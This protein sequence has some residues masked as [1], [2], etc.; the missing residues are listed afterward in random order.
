MKKTI[1]TILLALAVAA[2]GFSGCSSANGSSS[3]SASGSAALAS[4]AGTFP[5]VKNKTTLNILVQQNGTCSD[6]DTCDQTKAVE[7]KTGITIKWTLLPSTSDASQKL[8]LILSSN[9]LPDI[10]L[11]DPGMTQSDVYTLAQQ[12]TFIDLDSYIQKYGVETQKMFKKVSYSKELITYPDGKI[13][14]LPYINDCYHCHVYQRMFIYKPWLDKLGLKVPTTT[15]ELYN[16]LTAFKEKDPNGNGKADEVALEGNTSDTGSLA[17]FLMN[18]FTYYSIDD[19]FYVND[20]G[21]VVIPYSSDEWK[22]GLEYMRKLYKDGLVAPESFT[23]NEDQLSGIVKSSTETVGSFVDRFSHSLTGWGTD[24]EDALSN[25]YVAVSP[26]KGTNG[27]QIAVWRPYSSSHGDRFMI[28][29]ACK[30]PDVA[31]RLGDYL[32]SQE[33]TEISLMGVEGKGWTK[34]SSD[35]KGIDGREALYHQ[36]DNAPTNE[37]WGVQL[38]MVATNDMRMSMA[39]TGGAGKNLEVSLYQM[40]KNYEPY[41]VASKNVIPT[42]YFTDDQETRLSDLSQIED[43]VKES[44]ARFITG[45]LS[46]DKDWGSYVSELKSMGLSEYQQIYQDAYDNVKGK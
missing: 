27:T 36:N 46:I 31:F 14:S 18:A 11:N 28:T 35:E 10:F 8:K 12:G 33:Q 7:K 20:S 6:F 41:K 44:M 15:D 3:S 17:S 4:D 21:K 1:S 23:Q 45:D 30:N 22:A 26:L 9:D 39:A 24:A 38:P 43:Y 29:S 34:A 16:V 42:L 40:T 5:I 2:S 32:L 37:T 25:D 19:E 13:Y